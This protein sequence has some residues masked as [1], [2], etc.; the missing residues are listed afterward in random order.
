MPLAG[1]GQQTLPFQNQN[2][3][4]NQVGFSSNVSGTN[5][6]FIQYLKQ[7]NIECDFVLEL[8]SDVEAL[9]IFNLLAGDVKLY[10][11]DKKFGAKSD[12]P[13]RGKVNK[14]TV[15][16][17]NSIK[18]GRDADRGSFYIHHLGQGKSL[19]DI[20]KEFIKKFDCNYVT[21]EKCDT[22]GLPYS[23]PKKK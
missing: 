5:Y 7:L 20:R 3:S 6:Y 2:S 19:K 15:S 21:D 11:E 4:Q 18:K 8:H 23:N 13:E 9:K 12:Y 16:M 10:K 14:Y 17:N 1:S 22:I